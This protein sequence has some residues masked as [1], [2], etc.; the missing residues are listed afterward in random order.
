MQKNK[1]IV[2][3]IKKEARDEIEDS[4]DIEKIK[5]HVLLYQTGYLTIKNIKKDGI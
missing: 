2:N 3:N 5:I 1:N 4:I